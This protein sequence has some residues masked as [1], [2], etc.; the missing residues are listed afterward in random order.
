MVFHPSFVLL[1]YVFSDI[2]RANADVLA[3][4]QDI[5]HWVG[6]MRLAFETGEG[7]RFTSKTKKS[8]TKMKYVGSNS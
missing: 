7:G 6:E 8:L 2:S 1:N 3:F 4:A 5:V